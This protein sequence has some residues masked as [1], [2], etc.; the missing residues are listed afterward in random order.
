MYSTTSTQALASASSPA[1]G[2]ALLGAAVCG[3]RLLYRSARP[4]AGTASAVLRQVPVPGAAT[5][6]GHGQRA[7]ADL[8]RLADAVLEVVVRRVVDTVADTVDLTALVR[9]NVDLAGLAVDVVDAIDLPDIVRESSGA[10][11]SDA[12]QALRD[13]GM[14]ADDAVSR[15]VDR[16]LLRS[17]STSTS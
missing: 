5:L 14:Q 10:M 17:R 13:G 15:L 6:A 12:V 9:D 7:R 8:E 4:V 11:A 1:W 16:L 2:D 3:A